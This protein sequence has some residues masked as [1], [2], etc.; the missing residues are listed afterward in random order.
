[1]NRVEIITQF[2]NARTHGHRCTLSTRSVEANQAFHDLSESEISEL[3]E[4]SLT[5]DDDHSEVLARLAC[6]HPGSMNA[7]HE[8][9]IEQEIY[10]PEVIYH[11]AN[12]DCV[13]KFAD[14]ISTA[15]NSLRRRQL[16]SCM[17]WA[18]NA[19]VVSLFNIWRQSPPAWV[20]ELSLPP[21]EYS[22][23]AGWELTSEGERR[24]LFT[25]SAISLVRSAKSSSDDAPVQGGKPIDQ[26]CPWCDQQLIA[27]LDIDSTNERVSFLGLRG[28]RHRLITCRNCDRYGPLFARS[29]GIGD[30]SWHP[31][32]VRPSLLLNESSASLF[33]RKLKLADNHCHFMESASWFNVP[34]IAHSQIG[35]LPTWIN[36]AEYPNCPECSRKMPFIGQISSEDIH[37][38]YEE[39]IYF[40][41]ICTK[42]NVTATN[43]QQS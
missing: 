12:P 11:E 17:A 1:M 43:C 32:N 10:S 40:C 34:L 26:R 7:W 4:F 37:P 41:F 23:E 30:L 38:F 21:H 18:G 9:L 22:Y 20:S 39:R 28:S 31:S 29:N 33:E 25:N 16:L 6:S 19:E 5:A 3:I 35:G 2:H 36:D 42:C 13:R 14:L 8:R 15:A 27:V 24:N